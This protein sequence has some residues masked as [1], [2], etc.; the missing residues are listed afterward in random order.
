MSILR[1]I[2]RRQRSTSTLMRSEFYS[3]QNRYYQGSVKP[4]D[5]VDLKNKYKEAIEN[6]FPMGLQVKAYSTVSIAK[7]T[8]SQPQNSELSHEFRILFIG[9]LPIEQ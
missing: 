5:E 9:R 3:N 8:I 2:C 6:D 7:P 1:W 4:Q